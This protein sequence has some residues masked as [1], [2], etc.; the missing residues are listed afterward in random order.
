MVAAVPAVAE[1]LD[2]VPGRLVGRVG[3]G[4]AGT[5]RLA[6]L[7]DV[8]VMVGPAAGAVGAGHAAAS[9][10][11]RA[12]LRNIRSL[13][14]SPGLCLPLASGA[15]TGAESNRDPESFRRA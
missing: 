3:R 15:S 8:V 4:Q 7:L 9:G 12:S 5:D 6:I 1:A 11:N 14:A 10:L 2:G 13:G